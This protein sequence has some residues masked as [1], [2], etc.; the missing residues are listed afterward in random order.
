MIKREKCVEN[1]DQALNAQHADYIELCDNLAFGGTTPSYGVLYQSKKQISTPITVLIRARG[2][3]FVYTE[4]EIDIM[5]QDILIC[6]QLQYDSIRVGALTKENILDEKAMTTW[7]SLSTASSV[8]CH[9]AFD[10]VLDYYRAIDMLI[11]WGFDGVLTK[12]HPSLSAPH[13]QETLKKLIDYAKGRI[14]IIP[15]AGITTENY[16]EITTF[17]GAT[18]IHGTK[19]I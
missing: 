5:S 3:D 15:G 2:G 14:N 19:I 18:R 16:Q 10:K 13:N 12:G 7:K 6:N 8:S 4:E 11:E 9:M 17:T 1:F